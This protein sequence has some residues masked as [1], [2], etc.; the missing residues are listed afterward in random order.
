MPVSA[1]QLEV[2]REKAGNEPL[3]TVEDIWTFGALPQS[4][5]AEF[6]RSLSQAILSS[7]C[8]EA[9]ALLNELTNRLKKL[10]PPKRMGWLTGLFLNHRF[11]KENLSTTLKEIDNLVVKIRIWQA[12]LLKDS[13]LYEALETTIEESCAEMNVYI[14]EGQARL[15][16]LSAEQADDSFRSAL[17]HRLSELNLS[18]NVAEQGIAQI[19]VMLQNTRTIIQRLSPVLTGT[20]PLW[21]NQ[22]SLSLGLEQHDR[23]QILQ[24]KI[25]G[26]A[27]AALHQTNRRVKRQNRKINRA[28]L[29]KINSAEIANMNAALETE[30]TDLVSVVHE[31]N[32][33]A[34]SYVAA[35]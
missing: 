1:A 7:G 21:R 15:R 9:V 5:V 35:E 8:N 17:L 32:T 14:S 27:S 31:A 23:D 13:K 4:K 26:V 28:D 18:L 19:R 30:L 29:R 2:F 3:E 12:Q 24:Q 20:I 34:H 33:A 22:I 6:S 16:V 10:V 25:A 11:S